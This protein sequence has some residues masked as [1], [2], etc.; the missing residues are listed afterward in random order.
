M[1]YFICVQYDMRPVVRSLPLNPKWERLPTAVSYRY[2]S[3][4]FEIRFRHMFHADDQIVFF[5]FCYPFSYSECQVS[6]LGVG[7][8]TNDY[9]LDIKRLHEVGVSAILRLNNNLLNTASHK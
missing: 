9:F 7:T 5:A 8:T 1:T 6:N 2:T 4:G 3:S